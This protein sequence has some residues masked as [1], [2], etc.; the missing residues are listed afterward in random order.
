M[1]SDVSDVVGVLLDCLNFLSGVIIE[2]S[3]KVVIRSDN[4]PLFAGNEFCATDGRV[5]DLNRAHLSLRIVIVDHHGTT[6]KR[7]Q[8]P[9]KGGMQVDGLDSV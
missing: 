4:D 1:H 3:E 6:V 9:G 7:G 2:D 8:Y 5:G